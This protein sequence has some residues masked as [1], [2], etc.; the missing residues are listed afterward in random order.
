MDEKMSKIDPPSILDR[1]E[2][3]D[4]L[5]YPRKE[6][7]QVIPDHAKQFDITV[8]DGIK[9]N[10]RFYQSGPEAPHILFFHGN[11]E[12]AQDYDDIGQIYTQFNMNFMVVD[13]RGYG[14]SQGHPSVTSMLRDAHEVLNFI[15]EWL[16]RENRKG[17]L[18]VMG[19]S[20]GSAP[21]IELAAVHP[22]KI[23]GLIVE[24][25]FA[26]TIPLLQRLGI[27]V[28]QLDIKKDRV[29]SNGDKI[30]HFS[31]PTLIIHAQYDQIIP[32]S[33]GEELFRRSPAAIK[34]LHV[35]PDA[36]HNTILMMAGMSYFKLIES[37]ISNPKIAQ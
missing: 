33:H 30:K 10:T 6:S 18:W 27:D 12:I 24:S 15:L 7:G 3:I 13:Y 37:F 25:G 8:E 1:P 36:D 20:L 28:D 9:I 29:F 31:K 35:V 5:F 26:E 21:A 17:P 19:R 34:K 4:F 23:N 32:L 2:I 14:R 11:G 22:E 16:H